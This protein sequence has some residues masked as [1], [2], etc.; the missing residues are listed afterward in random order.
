MSTNRK[1]RM[2][3]YYRDFPENATIR[4]EYVK[5]GKVDCECFTATAAVGRTTPIPPIH[6]P[7]M[8]AYWKDKGKLRKKYIGKTWDDWLNR[9]QA[10]EVQLEPRILRKICLS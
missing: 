3:E 8:Y 1:I 9:R 10:K 7:Y 4:E 6:G 5:C 2:Y